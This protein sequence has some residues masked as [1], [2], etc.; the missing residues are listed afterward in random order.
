MGILVLRREPRAFEA[1]HPHT[2]GDFFI[3]PRPTRESIGSPPHAWGFFMIYRIIRDCFRF[4]P[5]R[6]GILRDVRGGEVPPPVHPHT[7]GDF[8][9]HPRIKNSHRGSPP[10]AWGFWHRGRADDRAG[11]FTPTRMG[12]FPFFLL[13]FRR[14]TVHPHTHGDFELLLPSP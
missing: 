10:H 2:H 4:T 12:I 9:Q 6:M 8:H 7:H 5:T 14:L 13:S 11:R 1:V 3:K